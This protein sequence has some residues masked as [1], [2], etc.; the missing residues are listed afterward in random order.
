M[1]RL[2]IAFLTMLLA[3]PSFATAKSCKSYRSCTEVISD[4]PNGKFGVRDRDKDG[5]PCENV[6]RSK[7]QVQDL[8]NAINGKKNTTR[9][10]K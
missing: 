3:F 9:K 4:Y 1:N 10:R 7:K 2:V 6:C 8:L 5:I